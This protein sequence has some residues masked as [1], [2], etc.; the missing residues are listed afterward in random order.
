MTS[1]HKLMIRFLAIACIL[2]GFI[3]PVPIA[4]GQSPGAQREP[5]YVSSQTCAVCHVDQAAAWSNSHHS[6]AWREPTPESVLGDFNDASIHHKGVTTRFLTR[7]GR[8]YLETDGSDGKPR[9]FEVKYTVGVEPL[10]VT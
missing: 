6:W 4:V 9:E 7:D 1:A 5:N 2:I 3:L 10:V 8:Y